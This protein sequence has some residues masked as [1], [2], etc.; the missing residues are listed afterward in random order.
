MSF[1][2]GVSDFI[3]VGTLA[4]S[5]YKSCKEAPNS[6]NN[7]HDEVQSLQI[8]LRAF[9][10]TLEEDLQ[11]IVE[12]YESLGRQSKRTWDRIRWASQDVSELRSRLIANTNLLNSFISTSQVTVMNSLNTFLRELQGGEREESVITTQTVESLSPDDREAWREIRK[13]LEEI[14]I[15]V[16]AFELNKNFILNWFREELAA[17]SFDE[18]MFEGL[19][20]ASESDLD[21]PLKDNSSICDQTAAQDA[22]KSGAVAG[23]NLSRDCTSNDNHYRQDPI[24]VCTPKVDHPIPA[25]SSS[26]LRKTRT[27]R[28]IS[29]RSMPLA[30]ISPPKAFSAQPPKSSSS[31][32]SKQRIDSTLPPSSKGGTVERRAGLPRQDTIVSRE[33]WAPQPS[34]APSAMPPASSSSLNS[35]FA[36]S[37]NFSSKQLSRQP[38]KSLSPLPP[39]ERTAR[40]R[41]RLPRLPA[42][43]ARLIYSGEDV[44]SAT[45][46]GSADKVLRLLEYGIN[47]NHEDSEGWTALRWAIVHR[48]QAMARLLAEH[49]ADV[50]GT[51]RTG[52]TALQLAVVHRDEVV[53]RLLVVKGANVESHGS[54]GLTALHLAV[55]LGDKAMVRLLLGKGA[56]VEAKTSY[57]WV[58][59]ERAYHQRKDA[60]VQLPNEMI[61]DRRDIQRGQAEQLVLKFAVDRGNEAI[62]RLPNKAVV[63]QGYG[64]VEANIA[65]T[66]LNLAAFHG[67]QAMAQLLIGKRA[68]VETQEEGRPVLHSAVCGKQEAMVRL[69][70]EKGAD[71]D[72]INSSWETALCLAVSYGDVAMIQILVEKGANINTMTSDMGAALHL[73]A[74]RG[75]EA[76]V[77]IL[78]E[79]GARV[80]NTSYIMSWTPLHFAASEEHEAVVRLLVDNGAYLDAKTKKGRNVTIIIEGEETAPHLAIQNRHETIAQLLV[81]RGADTEAKT[82]LG[83]KPL[84]S[85]AWHGHE[86]L[87]RLLLENGAYLEERDSIGR[88]IPHAASEGGQ[89]AVVRLLLEKGANTKATTNSRQTA[90]ELAWHKGHKAVMRLL[91]T[92]NDEA[93][94]VTALVPADFGTNC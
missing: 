56:A 37:P 52:L 82:T 61:A 7:I 59:L 36:E 33:A 29:Q 35:R 28:Q 55:V 17:G 10:D 81:E 75:D 58:A 23:D 49:G 34:N 87:V 6:F 16:A 40:R 63:H 65:L 4:W 21:R 78:V 43:V 69:L 73:A 84:F 42:L 74:F 93:A 85:A 2:Y 91:P 64:N 94:L 57:Q 77:Q 20:H 72:A 11:K 46:K 39:N 31:S 27:P 88:T 44:L 45:K 92:S 48:E 24:A 79:K 26:E 5:V 80:N 13:E 14:G 67:D 19:S 3:A 25:K 8:V 86:A 54:A 90:F 51:S 32:P 60:A 62:V 83:I 18:R 22:A 47:I 66:P 71:I 70:V 1:G 9:G 50:E 15:T 30:S 38:K 89:E 12:K 68:K 53:V 41:A 76:V